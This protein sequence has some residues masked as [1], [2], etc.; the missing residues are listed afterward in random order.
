M[1]TGII[2]EKG[3]VRSI[4]KNGELLRLI[5]SAGKVLEGTKR[6]DSIGVN[7]IC[8][9]VTELGAD[10]FSADVMPETLRR[11]SLSE[12]ASG[13]V[14]NLE[15]ALQV[16]ARLGGHLVSGH[17]DGVAVV[18]A[19]RPESHSLVLRLA[20]PEPL[21]RYITEKGSVSLDGTSLTVSA[22]GPGWFEVSLIPLTQEET[23]L[24]DKKIGDP[25]N[26]ECDQ[27]A[28][29]LERLLLFAPTSREAGGLTEGFLKEHGY[30]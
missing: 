23:I 20:P 16:G 1:F 11:T 26:I 30:V 10:F 29:Y 24:S 27:I 9:T 5:I 8:L 18:T 28:K 17:I 3:R 21:E 4:A 14:V 19:R 2:E 15:R 13:K 22:L 6:G 12:Q 7:G 25:V